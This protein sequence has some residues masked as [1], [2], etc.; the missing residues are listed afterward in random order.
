[1]LIKQNTKAKTF[2]RL[3]EEEE[4]NYFGQLGSS[5]DTKKK[6]LLGY[7]LYIYALVWPIFF[8]SII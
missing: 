2:I 6:V 5:T 7:F 3:D 1:M 4:R 8:F